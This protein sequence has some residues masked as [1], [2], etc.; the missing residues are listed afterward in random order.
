[1]SE[2]ANVT[3]CNRKWK[4]IQVHAVQS[5]EFIPKVGH[6]LVHTS[7]ILASSSILS[8]YHNSR[9]TLKNMRAFLA[10]RCSNLRKLRRST[11]RA[12]EARIAEAAISEGPQPRDKTSGILL[13]P[14]EVRRQII[15]Y[16]L[17]SIALHL[18]AGESGGRLKQIIY[19]KPH[20]VIRKRFILEIPLTCHQLYLET[21]NLIYSGNSFRLDMP[22]TVLSLPG[23]I[24]PQRLNMIQDAWVK[25]HVKEPP[26]ENSKEN[27]KW[28]K[29][30]EIIAS[31]KGLRRLLVQIFPFF[32]WELEWPFEEKRLLQ[33]TKLLNKVEIFVVEL[34]WLQGESP[35][36]LPCTVNRVAN[37]G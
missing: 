20:D 18:D 4:Q 21:V 29:V 6:E 37:S 24:L 27:R 1:M 16:C 30:W 35:L 17:C 32:I 8:R 19:M 13:L 23:K 33:D 28:R 2:D 26:K 25:W 34:G 14:L 15:E 12:L 3:T 11:P 31:L 10:S 5:F 9:I 22:A 36:E 7:I